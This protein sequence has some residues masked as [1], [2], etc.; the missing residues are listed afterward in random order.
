MEAETLLQKQNNLINE[1][2][3]LHGNLYEKEERIKKLEKE[4]DQLKYAVQINKVFILIFDSSR[5]NFRNSIRKLK[6]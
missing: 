2:E 1:I 4:N 5:T 3:R 6:R